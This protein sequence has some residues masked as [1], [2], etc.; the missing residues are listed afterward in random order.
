MSV[1]IKL[2]VSTCKLSLSEAREVY[3]AIEKE[4][5]IISNRMNEN[6]IRKKELLEAKNLLKD[7]FTYSELKG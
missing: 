4:E 3:N 2:L 5:K 1:I 7:K 6:I